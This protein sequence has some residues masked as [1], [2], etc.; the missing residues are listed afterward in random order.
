MLEVLSRSTWKAD[1]D[2]KRAVYASL[3]VREYWL[4]DPSGKRV[5]GRLRGMRL[6]G[7]GYRELAPGR[8][9]PGPAHNRGAPG[10][11]TVR[12]AVLG[13]D[14]CVEHDGG[15][16]LRDPV[17]AQVLPGYEEEHLAREAETAAREAAE[18]RAER[19]AAGRATEAT[20]RQA[21]EARVAELDAL[22]RELRSG[23]APSGN[24]R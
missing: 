2:A 5:A 10:G 21:A 17:T 11:R 13:L 22:V 15:L 7:A 8:S 3:G 19:E 20:A 23:R 18:V 4:Y 12:S 6:A 14:V 1:R 9:L 24:G 16:R